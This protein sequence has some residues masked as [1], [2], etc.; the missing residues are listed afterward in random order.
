M[1]LPSIERPLRNLREREA[2][3]NDLLETARAV[4]GG[5]HGMLLE[6]EET[7]SGLRKLVQFGQLEEMLE[8]DMRQFA[9]YAA[10]NPGDDESYLIAPVAGDLH[11]LSA[12]KSVRRNMT[13]SVIVFPLTEGDRAMG[14]IYLGGRTPGSLKADE[15]SLEELKS[16]AEV[17][18]RL[19]GVER[20][21][22]RLQRHNEAL[23]KQMSREVTLESLIGESEAI[24]RVRRSITLVADTDAVVTLVGEPG[25]GKSLAAEALHNQSHR[26][27]GRLVIL[28]VEDLPQEWIEEYVFGAEPGAGKTARGRRGALRDAKKGSLLL[29][30]VDHL[31]PEVQ[32]K[33]VAAIESGKATPVGGEEPYDL[34]VRLILATR[35]RPADLL[36]QGRVTSELHLKM[37]IYPILMPPL[38]DRVEDLP[39][40]V[41]NFVAVIAQ[42]YGKTV[43]GVESEVY[44]HL[45]TYDWPGNLEELEVEIRQAVLRT[46]D[47][48]E[49]TINALGPHLVGKPQTM[50]AD[51]GEGTLKQRVARVEKRMIIDAL[52]KNNHN[53]SVTA[54][55]LGL[56]RQALIN[57]LQRYGIETGRAYKRK[58]REIEKQAKNG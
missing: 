21:I 52:E 50:L 26:S 32:R 24:E 57:K 7:T 12:R 8:Q 44:D 4:C 48:G 35:E 55:Q 14:A 58:R 31:P 25:S 9:Q 5:D 23:Q 18:G 20:S 56:S 6:L 41:S 17:L 22:S 3:A 2:L 49:L 30:D 33:L 37:N 1:N 10:D 15:L 45:G 28:P 39:Q 54:D 36:E 40:L 47:N 42:S 11:K 53:Q 29:Q 38:R 27:E 43:A 46:P 16:L 34:N 19:L 13:S 51:S